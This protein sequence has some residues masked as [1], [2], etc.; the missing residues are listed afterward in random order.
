MIS[1]SDVAAG[2]AISAVLGLTGWWMCRRGTAYR[3]STLG[4][5][6][7]AELAVEIE[8]RKKREH[9]SKRKLQQL[10]QHLI[11]SDCER[12][13]ALCSRGK[14]GGTASISAGEHTRRGLHNALV[15]RH[16]GLLDQH[17]QA[18]GALMTAIDE[19]RRRWLLAETNGLLSEI[20]GAGARAAVDGKDVGGTMAARFH[21]HVTPKL[22]AI[23]VAYDDVYELALVMH[24]RCDGNAIAPAAAVASDAEATMR[25]VLNGVAVHAVGRYIQPALE[26]L[27]IKSADAKR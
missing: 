7:D 26:V 5:A 6:T 2:A 11:A 24:E 18:A 22:T 3:P 1:K 14:S 21:R 15:K 4:T 16:T 19:S 17:R 12:R 27:Q 9:I 13:Q 23:G 20:V 8:A 10:E 25:R